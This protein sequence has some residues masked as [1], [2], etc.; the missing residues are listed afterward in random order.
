MNDQKAAFIGAMLNKSILDE[1]DVE[2]ILNLV[3]SECSED[4]EAVFEIANESGGNLLHVLFDDMRLLEDLL[5]FAP[6]TAYHKKN[7][8]GETPIDKA[9]KYGD[10]AI[11]NLF[12]KY[13]PVSSLS[14]IELLDNFPEL[15]NKVVNEVRELPRNLRKRDVLLQLLN[16]ED[17]TSAG[18]RDAYVT[19]HFFQKSVIPILNSGVEHSMGWFYADEY[20]YER[21]WFKVLITNGSF[22]LPETDKRLI[23]QL[24]KS[25]REKQKFYLIFIDLNNAELLKPFT[26]EVKNDHISS[27]DRVNLIPQSEELFYSKTNISLTKLKLHL[28]DLIST[29]RPTEFID[30]WLANTFTNHDLLNLLFE[31]IFKNRSGIFPIDVDAIAISKDSLSFIEFKRKDHCPNGSFYYD[32]NKKSNRKEVFSRLKNSKRQDSINIFSLK[33]NEKDCYGLDKSHYNNVLFCNTAK[34]KINYDYVILHYSNPDKGS[35]VLNELFKIKGNEIV[36]K[37]DV[38]LKKGRLAPFW[39]DNMPFTGLTTTIRGDSG[40]CTSKRRYQVTVSDDLFEAL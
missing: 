27:A 5:C 12:T 14:D 4:L 39:W 30:K 17:F 37:I 13:G 32:F 22:E 38:V 9:F 31:R 18:F 16:N 35:S 28:Y 29:K 33:R 36:P 10:D 8:Y 3:D 23:V 20:N 24:S 11:V 15:K 26:A 34:P 2:T 40:N 21:S 25:K 6:E 1:N 7:R 19:E